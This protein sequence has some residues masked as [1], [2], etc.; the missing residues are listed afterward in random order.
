MICQAYRSTCK[1]KVLVQSAVKAHR[2]DSL[3]LVVSVERLLFIV[4]DFCGMLSV[5]VA[6]YINCC[7]KIVQ[8]NI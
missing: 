5:I 1:T 8:E 4:S 7:H 2:W 6:W 3:S